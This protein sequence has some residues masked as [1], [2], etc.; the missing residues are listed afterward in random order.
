[1]IKDLFESTINSIQDLMSAWSSAVAQMMADA[2][3]LAASF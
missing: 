1:M 3:Q 2:A